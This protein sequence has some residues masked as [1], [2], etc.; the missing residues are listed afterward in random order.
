MFDGLILVMEYVVSAAVGITF[1]CGL[2]VAVG[3]KWA[4]AKA[5]G[6]LS[7]ISLGCALPAI[8]LFIILVGCGWV[9]RP[10]EQ[11]ASLR[12]VAAFEIPL[13]LKS[14]RDELLSVLDAAAKAEGMHM[15]S[16]SPENL[17]QTA[18]VAKMT[19]TAAVWRGR[20]DED[21]IASVMDL[22][23]LDQVWITFSKGQNP[24]LSTRFRERAMREIM[25][26]WPGTLS[27]P[28]TPGGGLPLREDLVRKPGGYAV[29]PAAAH[30]YFEK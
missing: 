13:P 30:K 16:E 11:P 17:R 2:L 20:D 29:N 26:R 5:Q 27:L 18:G 19:I 1:I 22:D 21:L 4:P 10:V 24:A 28:I 3:R 7:S 9:L 23:H 6:Y 14:G 25:R 12:T 15:D 8:F